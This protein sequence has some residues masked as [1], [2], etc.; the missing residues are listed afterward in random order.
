MAKIYTVNEL[1]ALLK[2]T[3]EMHYPFV[4]VRGQVSNLSRPGSGHIY[5]TLKDEHAVLDAVWFKGKQ[6]LEQ[7][8]N[9]LTGEILQEGP[10]PS[11]A[12][13]MKNGE[14]ILCAGKITIYPPQGHLQLMV[15]LAEP[16]GI[17][18]LQ[19]K[20]EQLKKKLSQLGYFDLERKQKIPLNPRHVAVITAPTGA[21]IR[22]FL[23]VSANRGLSSKIRIYPSLIQ[24]DK[25][26][27]EIATA[28]NFVNSEKWAEVIVL[29]RGG[30][31]LE[32]LWTFNT[33]EVAAA[34][35]NSA[36]PVVTGIG[37]EPDI[38]IADLVADLRAATPSHAAQ[39]IW[40]ERD[41]L[42]QHVDEQELA[43]TS[44]FSKI[45]DTFKNRLTE[46]SRYLTYFSPL[47]SLARMEEKITQLEQ[48]IMLTWQK[49]FLLK[50]KNCEDSIRQ[51]Q[52]TF[53]SRDIEVMGKDL[54][55]LASRLQLLVKSRLEQLENME[56]AIL[57]T[58]LEGLNPLQPLQRGYAIVTAGTKVLR[59]IK[60]AKLGQN[61]TI[62]LS[63][64]TLQAVV[65]ENK[66]LKT[67]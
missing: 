36:L 27:S 45:I 20:F 5:F 63:D 49:N 30:G 35:F 56:F 55:E 58:K 16:F 15:E 42:V 12:L 2:G 23:R 31:S 60:D 64:G 13:S 14:E 52:Q 61:I 40:P 32:D 11:L 48:Q 29:I 7:K 25:A 33:E 57:K 9:P 51:L 26:P 34:I 62:L 37:H 66:R 8:F 39:L 67:D 21:V 41:T 44:I 54:S 19:Q 43:L 24:G 1:S 22:D 4:W 50:E 3:M 38:S 6:N 10:K 53:S 46:L 17:G 59:R 47:N 18:L 65:T 28:L